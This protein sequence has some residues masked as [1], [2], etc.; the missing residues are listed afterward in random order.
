[1]RRE[2][3]EARERYLATDAC[4]RPTDRILSRLDLNMHANVQADAAL[5]C[6]CD[7]TC[8]MRVAIL[9]A[10]AGC[11]QRNGSSSSVRHA[12]MSSTVATGSP[13]VTYARSF[14]S[15]FG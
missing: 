6:G 11:G 10:V 9:Q 2:R 3:R 4:Y 12:L 5:A 15:Q 13:A 14:N 8:R 1:M 7:F